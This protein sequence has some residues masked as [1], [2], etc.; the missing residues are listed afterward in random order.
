MN[1]VILDTETTGIDEPEVIQLAI[2]EPMATPFEHVTASTAYFK[3]SKPIA[4]GAVATH[5]ILDED[6]VDAAPWPGKYE[7][8]AG[9]G[10]LVGHKCDFDWAAIGKPAVKQICTLAFSRH[11]WPEL[12]SHS[13][14]AMTYHFMDR[15]EARQLLRGAHDAGTDVFLC[16]HLLQRIIDATGCKTWE[17]LYAACEIARVPTFM[18]FGKYGPFEA[19]AKANGGPMRC[20]EVRSRDPG[21]YRWLMNGCDQ[22]RDDPYLAKALRGNA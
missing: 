17:E 6:L 18:S 20:A 15:R 5:H 13:L 10:Y 8:P 21:Y 12:D 3:P 14:G 11:L 2:T 1:A 9:V 7:L 4:L 16:Y 22:V 19:W